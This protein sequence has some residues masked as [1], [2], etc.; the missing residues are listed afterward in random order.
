MMDE[1]TND[2]VAAPSPIR[3]H[4]QLDA[5]WGTPGG[6]GRLAA[7]NHTI[8][9]RRF[10]ATAFVFFGIGGIL[11][12]LIRAQLA[13]PR[14]AFL[15]PE[16]YNQIFTMHG[17]VMMFLFAIPMFE[18]FAMYLLPKLLGARDM[19]FP[20][21][22]A[23]GYW[24]YL[25]GGS[26][27][28]IAMAVGLAPN[29]GWF[30]YT[31]LSSKAYT[32][33]I[34]SDI[35][36]IGI[37]F[38]EIS[39]LS[40]AVEI[41]ATILKTR[42]PGMS[43]DKMPLLAWYLLVTAFMMLFGF[44]PLIL[45]SILL[46][47]ERAFDLPLFDPTRGGDALL[48]QHLF[49]LFGHP[50]VYIIFLP[51]AGMVSTIL[52]VL[53]RREIVGYSAIVI[54]VVALAFLSFGLWVHHMFTVG[55]PHLALAFFSSAS[56]AVAVPTAVQ[57]FAWIGTLAAGR[58]QLKLPML[59]LLGFFSVFV[60]GGLTGVM[61]AIVPF[62]WQVHDTHFVVAH[63]HY[64]LVG[65]FVF[66]MLAAAY[67]WLPHFT[68]RV[69]RHSLGVPAFWLII[70]GFNVTFL[71]MHLTGLLGM[72]RRIHGYGAETGWEWPNLVSSVG[73]FVMAIGFALFTVDVLLH[74]LH[75]KRS[76][77]N[78]WRAGTL[79]WAIAV[80]PTNYAFA[81]LPDVAT[82]APLQE[83]P[84]LGNHLARGGGYLGF[85]R[86]GWLETLGVD[87]MSGRVEQIVRLPNQTM[88]P[89]FTALVT[90]VFF[91]AVLFKLYVVALL[92]LPA[93]VAM[94]L[95]WTPVSGERRDRG[96]LPIGNGAEAV[97]HSEARSPP[98]LWAMGLTLAADATAFASLAF[99]ILFLW[100][101]A[102]NWPPPSMIGWAPWGVALSAGG[103]VTGFIAGRI[104]TLR[105]VVRSGRLREAALVI[106]LLGQIVALFGIADV[107][108]AVPPP[109]QHAYAAATTIILIYAGLHA[110]LAAVFAGFGIWRSRAG[111]VSQTRTVD[112]RIGAL[113]S[114]FT[115]AIGIATLLI[116][117][118]L[119]LVMG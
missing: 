42:A 21:L 20:R 107:I 103:L 10:I 117:Y 51:A 38:V 108:L 36:L 19:A 33:G 92:A 29:G 22:S 83:R 75:G 66:P 30:M 50:E 9:G 113:W 87:V 2:T 15:G 61:L 115:A 79:E 40:A 35:W 44:P 65:G 59:Y 70:I 82:R 94:L 74:W 45:G 5:V 6:W 97:L 41:I 99:G 69:P 84:D 100:V 80:P 48:W 32:P 60:I 118:G 49:W 90:G 16:I 13:T 86:N 109:T 111:Y 14:S 85:V 81:S 98:S 11:A 89:L 53:A 52:P 31:P 88:L 63:L 8:V 93:I 114:D 77:R 47:V 76:A 67:Y 17:T 110:A 72:P 106:A 105:G 58:P 23:Y 27:L 39:A 26:M 91:V 28:L 18:G 95:A 25:F 62:N 57:I 12:M 24:C 37:T 112:L 7:V 54:S 101:V 104:A 71:V 34:N 1:R 43:L 56:T 73:S 68:G 78:P 3:L 102:P 116:V 46:E 55:I 64:V 4:K 96:A 119:P